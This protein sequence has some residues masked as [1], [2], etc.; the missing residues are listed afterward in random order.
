M[1]PIIFVTIITIITNIDFITILN[2]ELTSYI[3]LVEEVSKY[4][5]YARLVFLII[6]I[7]LTN[8]KRVVVFYIVYL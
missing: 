5:I 8:N 2:F 4:I 7:V 3:L 1:L 6:I